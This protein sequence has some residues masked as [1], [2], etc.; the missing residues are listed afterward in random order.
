M[1]MTANRARRA[2]ILALTLSVFTSIAWAQ[3]PAPLP[4]NYVQVSAPTAQRIVAAEKKQ[5]VEIVKLGLHAVPPSLDVHAIIG[6]DN[7]Q[8]VGKKSS[9][10]DMEKLATGNPVAVRV[11]KDKIYDLLL[12]IT[13]ANGGDIGG[14]FVV[15]EVPFSNAKSEA[16]ALKIGVAIRD[17]IQKQIPSREALYQR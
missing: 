8:K 15:M 7:L 16:E 10:A 6:S 17:E 9:A 5:H 4:A 13:D 1:I 2:R 12:P 14:G 11:E 3:T